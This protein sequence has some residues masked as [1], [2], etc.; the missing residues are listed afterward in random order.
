MLYGVENFY[1]FTY[2]NIHG[3]VL[4]KFVHVTWS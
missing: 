2:A 4:V 1:K 3:I